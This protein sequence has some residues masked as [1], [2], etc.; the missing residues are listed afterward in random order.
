MSTAPA[1]DEL[2]ARVATA[3]DLGLLTTPRLGLLR[4]WLDFVMRLEGGQMT[5]VVDFLQAERERNGTSP[6]MAISKLAGDVDGYALIQLAAILTH[7]CQK[8]ATDPSA[9][10]TRPAF[11]SHRKETSPP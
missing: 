8:C 2:L 1:K 5:Y 9:W 10:H 11:C 3:Y 7:P 4:E 6:N